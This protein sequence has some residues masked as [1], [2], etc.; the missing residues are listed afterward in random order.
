[1]Q[2]GGVAIGGAQGGACTKGP[3]ATGAF[4]GRRGVR[5]LQHSAF[6][7][8]WQLAAPLPVTQG[9]SFH[10]AYQSKAAVVHTIQRP[11]PCLPR[12]HPAANKAEECRPPPT[13]TL[14]PSPRV[15]RPCNHPHPG[16][17]P[18]PRDVELCVQ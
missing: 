12:A 9:S 10:T 2:S 18:I 16:A 6:R 14:S 1:V 4:K 3:G 17:G 13:H 8:R 11:P 5:F 15:Q 7:G